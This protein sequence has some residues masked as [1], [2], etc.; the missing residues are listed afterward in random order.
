MRLMPTVMTKR[1][2]HW[3]ARTASYIF[4]C[5]DIFYTLSIGGYKNSGNREHEEK[6]VRD[7]GHNFFSSNKKQGK[8]KKRTRLRTGQRR[9]TEKAEAAA[10]AASQGSSLSCLQRRGQMGVAAALLRRLQLQ[11]NDLGKVNGARP[12]PG[13]P[14]TLLVCTAAKHRWSASGVLTCTASIS[15]ALFCGAQQNFCAAA[16]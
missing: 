15:I 12:L 5:A 4:S 11:S 7:P 2:N 3:V 1:R 14:Y 6:S 10:V 13:R 8:N 9:S 16:L